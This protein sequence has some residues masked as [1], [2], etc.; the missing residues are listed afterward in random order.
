MK[1]STQF[2]N[3]C[4][5]GTVYALFLYLSIKSKEEVEQ[6]FFF[7]NDSIPIIVQKKYKNKKVLPRKGHVLFTLFYSLYLQLLFRTKYRFV[8]KI[9]M[10]GQDHLPYAGLFLSRV[11]FYLLEDGIGTYIEQRKMVKSKVK[12]W[13]RTCLFGININEIYSR[14]YVEKALLTGMMDIPEYLHDKAVIIKLKECFILND[15]DFIIERLALS[16]DWNKNIGKCDVLL[17]TQSFSECGRVTEN[18]KIDLYKK[19]LANYKGKS[20]VIK[21]HPIEKTDYS[22]FFKNISILPNYIPIQ[23]LL[24]LG[25]C[26]S[27]IATINSSSVFE[28]KNISR[29]DWYGNE[30]M[31]KLW[32]IPD[33]L[34]FD[35]LNTNFN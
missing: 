20:I 18:E 15:Q 19:I 9:P 30:G 16:D 1:T 14:K 4:Y 33:S 35:K 25:L 28:F 17:I 21:P 23:V 5:V 24:Y 3:S 29:I 22:C 11:V 26:P 31:G 12:E 32:K 27:I 13:I 8:F 6:T 7:F 10:Y 34:Q 2:L